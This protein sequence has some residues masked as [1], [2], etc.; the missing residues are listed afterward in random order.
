MIDTKR[1]KERER[2]RKEASGGPKGAQTYLVHN[3]FTDK[4]GN[5]IFIMLSVFLG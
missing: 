4:W 1:N 5:G 3:D 2:E